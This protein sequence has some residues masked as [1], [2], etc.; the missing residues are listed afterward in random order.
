MLELLVAQVDLTRSRFKLA[1]A[2]TDTAS[3]RLT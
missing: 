1:N 2:K 3:A